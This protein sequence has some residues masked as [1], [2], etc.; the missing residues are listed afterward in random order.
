MESNGKMGSIRLTPRQALICAAVT[1]WNGDEPCSWYCP[2]NARDIEAWGRSYLPAM[3]DAEH[4]FQRLVKDGLFL[5]ICYPIFKH[6]NYACWYE[7]AFLRELPEGWTF[8]GWQEGERLSIQDVSAFWDEQQAK[9]TAQYGSAF[10]WWGMC[11]GQGSQSGGSAWGPCLGPS[12][13]WYTDGKDAKCQHD[14]E[15]V[16]LSD[17]VLPDMSVLHD[18][19]WA[20]ASD[21]EKQRAMDAAIVALR[22]LDPF[23]PCRTSQECDAACKG[24]PTQ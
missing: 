4:E 22:K 13:C 9:S 23:L 24:R 19:H 2:V 20:D 5:Q 11:A 6:L 21:D 14:L 10:V 1:G 17:V 8:P 15:F 7:S 16:R 18:I 3:R 12:C